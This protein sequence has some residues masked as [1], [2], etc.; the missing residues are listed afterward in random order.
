ML[1]CFIFTACSQEPS[2]VVEA[3]K[4]KEKAEMTDQERW[5][6]AFES[7]VLDKVKTGTPSPEPDNSI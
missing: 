5:E 7:D 1:S 4:S 6:K 2:K 3:P